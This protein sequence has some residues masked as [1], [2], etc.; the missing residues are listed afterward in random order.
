MS[1]TERAVRATTPTR[2]GRALQARRPRVALP[3]PVLG[4]AVLT[5]LLRLPFLRDPLTSDEGGYLLIVREWSHGSSTYGPYFLDR[6]PLL[7][8]WY[9]LVDLI[10]PLTGQVA[11]VRL[12]G[13]LAAALTVVGVGLAVRRFA[14]DTPSL[15]ASLLTGGLMV[16]PL[17]G[18]VA[19]DGE[20][21]AAPFIAFGAWL[22]VTA[23][24]EPDRRRSVRAAVLAGV[25][26]AGAVLV[27]QNMID[28]F[29]FS[30]VLAL[31]A[32]R[33]GHL[34]FADVRRLALSLLGG[35]LATVAVV[36]AYAGL[37]GTSLSDVFFSMYTF[38]A[39][40]AGTFL[41][42]NADQVAIRM[43]RLV[44]QELFS[45]G[46]LL[47]GLLAVLWHRRR[48]ARTS[49]TVAVIVAVLALSAY[50]VFSVWAGGSAWGHY[51]VQFTVPTGLAAGL[52]MAR[53]SAI[54][55]VLVSG[56]VG[57]AA[58]AWLS[59]TLYPSQDP[60]PAIGQAIRTVA[61]P[62]DTMVAAL[63][64]PVIVQQAGMRTPYP[65][66][67]SLQARPLDPHFTQLRD[68]LEGPKA[69]A[70][71]V[72]RGP[73]TL[74]LLRGEAPANVL[75]SRYHE[76][77][78]MCDRIVLLRDDVTRAAPVE[79]TVCT[80]SESTLSRMRPPQEIR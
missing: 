15:W 78:Q 74:T 63:G 30:G 64:D 12:V 32:W 16:S 73:E 54:A 33:T 75:A 71:V 57:V 10:S 31:V 61:A 26:A 47:V 1:I 11:A 53:G 51:A 67:W 29:L 46:V 6:P 62:G 36:L 39:K 79:P 43:T 9:Q 2:E 28:V 77:A 52:L 41:S 5:F 65:Y 17:V 76:V 68:L 60:S 7:V 13:S 34:A 49:P 25:C 19:T 37:H 72:V 27:K 20:I 23:I 69:P 56:C 4:V 21:L 48:S 50:A 40:A 18:A 59:G 80:G 66:L 44:V 70:W 24:S 22:A 8:V 45:G 55:R 3:L 38:R 58:V 35:A 14:G 42:Y